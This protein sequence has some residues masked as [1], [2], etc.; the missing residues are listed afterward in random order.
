ML[1]FGPDPVRLD[2]PRLETAFCPCLSNSQHRI[3]Q[4]IAL[5]LKRRLRTL[6]DELDFLKTS[7]V[8]YSSS[9]AFDCSIFHAV[10]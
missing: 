5:N 3:I 4:P 8:N 7:P 2:P 6:R 9:A 10:T 1:P